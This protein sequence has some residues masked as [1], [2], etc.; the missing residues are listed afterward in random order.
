MAPHGDDP[1]RLPPCHRVLHRLR[2][3]LTSS[4]HADDAP[5]ILG[6][7]HADVG[8]ASRNTIASSSRLLV[9]VLS[10]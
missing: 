10:H 4:D 8:E 1:R 9:P 6:F 3:V 7:R 5:T 2:L